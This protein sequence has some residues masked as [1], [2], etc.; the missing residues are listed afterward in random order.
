MVLK[1][2]YMAEPSEPMINMILF[3]LKDPV[4]DHF[5]LP[6]CCRLL[7]TWKSD[8][9]VCVYLTNIKWTRAVGVSFWRATISL[10]EDLDFDFA[11]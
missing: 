2:S 11:L 5:S 1:L 10:N 3:V 6:F 7:A 8:Q 4:S 9:I